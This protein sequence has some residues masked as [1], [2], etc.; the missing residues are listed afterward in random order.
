MKQVFRIIS[1]SFVLIFSVSATASDKI[2]VVNI[3][4]IFQ[5]LPELVVVTHKLEKEFKDRTI[6]L[7][8]MEHDL[9]TKI[10]NMQRNRSTMKASDQ[11]QMEKDIIKKREEFNTTVR[12]FDQ[13]TRRRQ[14]EERDKI[15]YKIQN[16]VQKVSTLK[17]YDL[18]LDRGAVAYVS[19]VRDITA[20]V[21]KQV[22]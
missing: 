13:D 9:Q 10:Q 17:G 15:I 16:A 2:A 3:S 4:D 21:L 5:Q 20:D 19:S 7:Q 14:I 12:V 22:K 8:N 6:A 18:V 11:L 1:L